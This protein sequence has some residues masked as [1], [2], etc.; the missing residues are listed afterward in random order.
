MTL[1]VNIGGPKSPGGEARVFLDNGST[2]DPSPGHFAL[3]SRI[4]ADGYL[5]G[6]GFANMDFPSDDGTICPGNSAP[7][8]QTLSGDSV[9]IGVL[10]INGFINMGSSAD[11]DIDI[12]GTTNYDRL[13]VNGVAAVGGDVTVHFRGYTPKE[14]DFFDIVSST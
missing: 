8:A 12:G 1:G 3:T 2:L 13:V 10:T 7:A 5:E 6:T 11:L 4:F 14:R 9:G